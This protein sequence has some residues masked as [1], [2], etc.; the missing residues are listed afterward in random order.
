VGD[1][2]KGKS[3]PP[4]QK[5]KGARRETHLAVQKLSRVV[6][7]HGLTGMGREAHPAA[8]KLPA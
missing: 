5:L 8:Q 2:G 1:R 4:T 6:V 7:S 3:H